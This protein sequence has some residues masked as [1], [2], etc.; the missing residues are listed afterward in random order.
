[1]RNTLLEF[2]AHSTLFWSIVE[3][4]DM[5]DALKK[6]KI[7]VVEDEADI[8][9]VLCFFLKLSDFEVLSVSS[10]QQAI[11]VIPTYCPDLIILD[12]K[13]QP[14]TGWEVLHWLR[15][16]RLTSHLPVLVVTACVQLT[17]QLQGFE[18]G[19]VD[20]LTKP[21]QPS[22]IVERVRLLLSLSMEERKM[23][24]WKRINEQHEL[25]KRLQAS[26]PDEFVH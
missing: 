22:V 16:N 6:H 17:E 19:A 25:I 24:Q 7:L 11:E 3:L 2:F 18:Q 8:R 20:Y 1:M 14:V 4:I 5:D 9:Q 13:M 12:I 10:G 15:E 21:T 26:L 23:L